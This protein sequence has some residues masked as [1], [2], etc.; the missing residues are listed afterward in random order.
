MSHVVMSIIDN[1]WKQQTTNML[2]YII[3]TVMVMKS[4]ILRFY[5]FVGAMDSTL[6]VVTYFH[7][8][9][10]SNVQLFIIFW[11]QISQFVAANLQSL[12]VSNSSPQIPVMHWQFIYLK[13]IKRIKTTCD[14][15]WMKRTP[16]PHPQRH[17][18][19]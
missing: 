15:K 18:K 4:N 6:I 11:R 10:R 2:S 12:Q 13:R 14:Y 3:L 1:C 17:M 8:Y 19:N 5:L 16:L 9:N 7:E